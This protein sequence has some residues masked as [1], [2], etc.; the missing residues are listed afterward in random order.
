[1]QRIVEEDIRHAQRA[2]AGAVVEPARAE[3]PPPQIVA[4]V[5]GLDVTPTGGY[6]SQLP[7]DDV[8][9][10]AIDPDPCKSP[11]Q[12]ARMPGVVVGRTLAKQLDVGL[13]DCVQVTSPQIGFSLGGG[14]RSP[15]AKQFR[16]IAIF[17]AGF[18][19]YDSKLVYADLYEAQAFYEYGD[20]VTGI[21]MRLDDIN[22]ADQVAAVITK[23]LSN[24]IYNTMTWYQLNRGLFTAL[25]IQRLGMSG[26]LFLIQVVATCTVIATMTM[27]VLEKRKE[28]ALLKALGAKTGAIVRIFLYQGLAIGLAGTV[29]G[30]AIGWL[31]LRFLV[32]YAF[33]LDPKVYFISHLPVSYDP[34]V[35]VLPAALAVNLCLLATILP[36]VFAA[37][38][39]PA[40]GLRAE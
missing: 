1:M 7:Q 5:E 37:Q 8:L 3:L 30:L 36:A 6:R 18:D 10:D 4:P 34:I 25:E 32:V 28:V 24:G 26:A 16:V 40:D 31:G 21:E 11:E 27:V 9:P 22:R 14:V 38:L 12:V 39:R 15:I 35:F 17:E 20:S 23:R 2:D 33:P 13:G 29:L 19:Q